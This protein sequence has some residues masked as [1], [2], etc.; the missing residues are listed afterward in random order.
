MAGWDVDRLKQ[1]E[2]TSSLIRLDP[3]ALPQP[4]FKKIKTEKN[5][6]LL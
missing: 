6:F 2:E 3:P 1:F 4:S 5:Y